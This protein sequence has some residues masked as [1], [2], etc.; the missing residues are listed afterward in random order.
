M[1][2]RISN[3]S[4]AAPAGAPQRLSLDD[5]LPQV[6]AFWEASGAFS[7]QSLDRMSETVARFAARLAASGVRFVD[8]V[9]PRLAEAFIMAPR[10]GGGPPEVATTHVRRSAVRALFRALRAMGIAGADP[11]IDVRLSP[12]GD[13]AARPLIDDE[14]ALC[15][16][17]AQTVAKPASVTVRAAAWALAEATGV[18]TEIARVRVSDL[19]STTRPRT[20]RLFGGARRDDRTGVLTGWGADAIARRLAQLAAAGAGPETLV[21]YGGSA[22][23]GSAKAQSSVCEAIRATLIAAGLGAERGVRPSSV[24]H[25]AG[26]AAFDAGAPIEKVAAMMGHRSLDETA[27]DIG[28]VWRSVSGG[29]R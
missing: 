17:S 22:P 5:A 21:A 18:S 7:P 10:R 9:T 16:I 29:A 1:A 8:E 20:V 28:Y 19:D 13:L 2:R 24:R 26:R 25:W 23:A 27:L 3:G 11:T 6:F 12:R 4:A 15:R 14:I